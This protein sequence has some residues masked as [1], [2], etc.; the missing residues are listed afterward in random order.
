MNR[1]HGLATFW[2]SKLKADVFFKSSILFKENQTVIIQ[3][4]I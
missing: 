2:I 1:L 4:G 3:T